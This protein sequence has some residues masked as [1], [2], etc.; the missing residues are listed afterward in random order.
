MKI[1]GDPSTDPL[2][3]EQAAEAGAMP[4]A[5]QCRERRGNEDH[6]PS[7]APERRHQSETESRG[8]CAHGAVGSQ[9]AELESVVACRE[10]PSITV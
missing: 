4:G 2:E 5:E 7:A 3:L 1:G 8:P 6:E 10:V 9:G